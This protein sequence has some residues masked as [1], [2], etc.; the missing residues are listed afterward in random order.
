MYFCITALLVDV[1]QNEIRKKTLG[2]LRQYGVGITALL[3]PQHISLKISFATDRVN[4]LLNYFDDLCL[5]HQPIKVTLQNLEVVAID[6]LGAPTG[7]L[8]YNVSDNNRLGKIH[9]QLNA[10][11]PELLGINNSSIDG[12]RFRFRY[13]KRISRCDYFANEEKCPAAWQRQ[14][15]PPAIRPP[16]CCR[17]WS[18][19]L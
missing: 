19:G 3:L 17:C 7:L 6:Y 9:S 14:S 16:A 13:P 10:D 1:S 15:P 4:D 12:N 5:S 11:L 2:L 18:D 8:W